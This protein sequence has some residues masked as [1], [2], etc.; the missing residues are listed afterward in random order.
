MSYVR[1]R[2]RETSLMIFYSSICLWSTQKKKPIFTQPLAHGLHET[3]SETEGVVQ[4]PRWITAL[5]CLHYSDLIASGTS[6]RRSFIL[7]HIDITVRLVGRY[8]PFLEARL[9]AQVL[10]SRRHYPRPRR[11]QLFAARSGTERF[12]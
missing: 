12:L 9:E 4:T 8:H 7:F 3:P 5:A 2:R 11:R 6:S 1:V 10:L